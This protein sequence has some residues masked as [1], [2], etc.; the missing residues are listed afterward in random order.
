VTHPPDRGRATSDRNEEGYAMRTMLAGPSSLSRTWWIL[1]FRG[2]LALLFGVAAL[3]WPRITL[4]GLVLGFGTY[5]LVDGLAAL[6]QWMRATER[7]WQG[8]ALFL[9]GA[10]S[11]GL[12]IVAW[13]WPFTISPVLLYWIATWGILTGVLELFAAVWLLRDPTAQWLFGLAGVSSVLLG[14][15][16]IL[17]PRAGAEIVRLVGLY[18]VTFGVLTLLAA[19]WLRRAAG[20]ASRGSQFEAPAAWLWRR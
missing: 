17:L 14:I 10:V 11:V 7:P 4:G 8:A 9:E 20:R 16:L 2:L 5:A 18:A 3:T 12:G 1:A 15:L 13:G 19:F 6:T